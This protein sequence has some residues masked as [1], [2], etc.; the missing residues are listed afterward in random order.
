MELMYYVICILVILLSNLDSKKCEYFAI[1]YILITRL[2]GFESDFIY[3]YLNYLHLEP[4]RILKSPFFLRELA[5][6]LPT[7][8]LFKILGNATLT[9]IV[10]DLILFYFLKK[11][12]K[13]LQLPRMSILIYY[14]LFMSI[15]GFQNVYRQFIGTSMILIILP[16]LRNFKIIFPILTHN[17]MF[18][19]TAL[20]LRNRYVRIIFY[21]ITSLI[22]IYYAQLKSNIQSGTGDFSLLY[23][24]AIS[25]NF[26]ISHLGNTRKKQLLEM[27]YISRILFSLSIIIFFFL[28]NSQSERIFMSILTITTIINLRTIQLAIKQRQ[29]AFKTFAL[30]YIIPTLIFS[31]ARQF[32]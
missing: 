9:F 4:I 13:K 23:F 12:F 8:F 25:I 21:L 11:S 7:S 30:I 3:N 5:Y 20:L 22:F 10:V 17:S 2:S 29:F 19:Y 15:F 26:Y 1:G 24:I 31:S 28:S 27:R 32:L 14:L 6:Y 18:I 16:S